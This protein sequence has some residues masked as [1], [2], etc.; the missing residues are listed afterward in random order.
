MR[1]VSVDDLKLAEAARLED[2]FS[3]EA[4]FYNKLNRLFGSFGPECYLANN[5]EIFME[6]LK[7]KNFIMMD[8][9]DLLDLEH[10]TAVL[11]VIF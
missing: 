1:K 4:F 9:S 3:T 2:L 10:C 8:K 7:Q 11:Q 5:A 6:N